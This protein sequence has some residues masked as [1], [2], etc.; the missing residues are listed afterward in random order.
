MIDG[1]APDLLRSAV[2]DIAGAFNALSVES[3]ARLDPSAA[4]PL[5]RE[6]DQAVLGG[7]EARAAAAIDTWR[8]DWLSRCERAAAPSHRPPTRLSPCLKRPDARSVNPEV[9]V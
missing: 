1:R 8:R 3:Q 2:R 9:S 5:E 6:V 7:D 4:D